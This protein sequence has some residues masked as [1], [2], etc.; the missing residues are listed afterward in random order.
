MLAARKFGE[1]TGF[2]ETARSLR[3]SARAISTSTMVS[4]VPWAMKNGGAPGWMQAIGED[5]SRPSP[6]SGP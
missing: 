3:A 5:G 6:S 4:L 1:T 2:A